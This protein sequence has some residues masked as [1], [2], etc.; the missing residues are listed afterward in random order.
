MNVIVKQWVIFSIVKHVAL[1]WGTDLMTFKFFS[2]FLGPDLLITETSNFKIWKTVWCLAVE[3]RFCSIC[4]P[5]FGVELFGKCNKIRTFLMWIMQIELFS[6]MFIMLC[7]HQITHIIL[8][9]MWNKNA[10]HFRKYW[11]LT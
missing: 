2:R 11:D 10:L 7:I 6:V 8:E 5:Q 4:T 9:T 3:N 1:Q